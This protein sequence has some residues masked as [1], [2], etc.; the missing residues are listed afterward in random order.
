MALRK[1]K[2]LPSRM[3]KWKYNPVC[4]EDEES[5]SDM[6]SKELNLDSDAELNLENEGQSA[7]EE[8]SSALSE[9]ECESEPSVVRIDGWEDVTMGNK[10]HKAYTFTKNAGP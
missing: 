7:S 2:F 5:I 4:V 1:G 6:L 10:K 9:S 3:K 8:S